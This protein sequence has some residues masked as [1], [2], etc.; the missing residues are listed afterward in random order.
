MF[1]DPGAYERRSETRYDDGK[2][3]ETPPKRVPVEDGMYV[4]WENGIESCYE[5]SLDKASEESGEEA[6]GK[7]KSED[8]RKGWIVRETPRHRLDG[9]GGIDANLALVKW[10]KVHDCVEAADAGTC[11]SAMSRL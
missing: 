6:P 7:Q 11:F 8:R 2:K 5:G 4:D 1:V 10:Y 3:D 9:L